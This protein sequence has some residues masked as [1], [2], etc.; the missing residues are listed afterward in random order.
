M[1]PVSR[2]GALFRH[3]QESNPEV[4][5]EVSVGRSEKRRSL[6]RE[7]VGVRCTHVQEIRTNKRKKER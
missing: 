5:R 2:P 3:P 1:V 4:I 6:S 7:A